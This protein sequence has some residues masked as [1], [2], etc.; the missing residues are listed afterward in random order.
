MTDRETRLLEAKALINTQPDEAVYICN[1][2]LNEDFE[3]QDGQKALFMIA[4]IMLEAGRLGLAYN[5]YK[6]CLELNPK[7]SYIYSNMGRAFDNVDKPR[8][9]EV[10][11]HAIKIN[12]ANPDAWANAGHLYMEMGQPAKCIE[13]SNKALSLNA[14]CTAARHNIAL[15]NIMLKN[16]SIG[17]G[18]YAASL[19]CKERP[20]RDYGLE[21]LKPGVKGGRLL[22]YGEQGV[23]DEIM[24][25]SCLADAAKDFDI[26][27]DTDSR[28]QSLFA[29]SFDFPVYGTRFKDESPILSEHELDYQV[30]IGQL[31]AIYRAEGN[32]PGT[33]YLKPCPERSIMWRALF[34]TFKG[35]KIGIAWT[36]GTVSNHKEQRCI[37]LDTFSQLFDEANTYV[38][39]E[40]NPVKISDL[41][42]YNL[43][44]YPKTVGKGQDIDDLAA[45][46]S[47]LDMVITVCTTVL[48]IAGALGK[49]CH[50][51][52]PSWPPPTM[53]VEGNLP[54]YSSVHMH[55]QKKGESWNKVIRRVR[56][57]LTF[58]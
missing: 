15:S 46:I 40:Y 9:L 11:K 13:Y 36:G 26:V 20:V 22:V 30:A 18:Q 14:D 54:W 32:F 47:Q 52:V 41:E 42:R 29:R 34:D 8:A 3:G 28:L 35:K 16:W 27:L 7:Q 21:D 49:E 24:F 10:Y 58:S 43:K 23:G 6:R 1:E 5:L 2:I 56:Q 45:L 12:P 25:A 50:V 48:H 39:L 33:P 38:C 53:H 51:L 31:P 19:G 55:R 57:C 4:Y 44:H 17:W 37:D